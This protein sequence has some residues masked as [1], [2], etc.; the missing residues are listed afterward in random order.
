VKK[1]LVMKMEVYQNHGIKREE[2]QVRTKKLNVIR[3]HAHPLP[4]LSRQ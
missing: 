1:E 4:P 3:L 2:E